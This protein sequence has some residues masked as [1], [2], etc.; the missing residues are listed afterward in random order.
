ML[1]ALIALTLVLR[2]TG[3]D[4]LQPHL[5]EA[6]PGLVVQLQLLREGVEPDPVAHKPYLAYPTLIARG[7]ALIPEHST[8]AAAPLEEQLAAAGADFVRMRT[9]IALLASLLVPLTWL[10]ARRFLGDFGALTAC[11]FVALSLLHQLFSQQARPHGAHATIALAAVLAALAFQKRPSGLR[12]V[13]A[14][15]ACACA[16]ACL[17]TGVFT[18][19]PLVVAWWFARRDGQRLPWWNVVLALV[20]SALAVWWLYPRPPRIENDGG[21]VEFGGHTLHFDK[22]DFTGLRTCATVM[23]DYDPALLIAASIGAVLLLVRFARGARVKCERH[24]EFA[25]VFAYAGSYALALSVFGET[26]DRFLLPLLPYFGLL[27]G[28]A[29][30]SVRPTIVRGAFAVLALAWPSFVTA[31]YVAVRAASD[32]FELAARWVDDNVASEA[33]HVLLSPRLVLP[34]DH[35]ANALE[36]AK[37]DGTLR[38]RPWIRR[39]LDGAVVSDRERFALFIAPAKLVNQTSPQADE[40]VA[41][42]LDEV[43]PKYALIEQSRLMANFPGVH[44]LRKAIGERGTLVTTIRGEEA[45]A[46]LLPPLDYQEIP[47]FAQRL[48]HATAFGPCIEIYALREP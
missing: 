17:H 18:L 37:S 14:S 10:L 9:A 25:V 22:L 20:S 6:D 47:D 31:R 40:T 41:R 4:K 28:V 13:L 46:C 34:L 32:T 21:T 33:E 24:P 29:V 43:R 8:E 39:Q 12:L 15:L 38:K 2:F 5:D 35:S 3:L 23:A 19:V 1:S 36:F 44:A 45:E 16:I 11:A 48:L 30:E 27:A 7:V 42:L 26:V